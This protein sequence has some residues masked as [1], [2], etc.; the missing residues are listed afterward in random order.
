MLGKGIKRG[1]TGFVSVS[2]GEKVVGIEDI[3]HPNSTNI[4]DSYFIV[5]VSNLKDKWMYL[6]NLEYM[7]RI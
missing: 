3:I 7:N 4:P 5:C 6:I 2:Y 1:K